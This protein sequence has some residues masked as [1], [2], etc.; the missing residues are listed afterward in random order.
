[1]V[2]K[3]PRMALLRMVLLKTAVLVALLT[4]PPAGAAQGVKVFISADMEGVVGAVTGDQL[5]P[6]G[7][8]YQKFREYMTQEVNA[9][10][11]GARAAGATEI[12][13][14]DSHGNGQNLLMDLLPD[15]I[16]LV[17][18][19]PREL[20]MMH[21]VDESFDAAILLG[22]HAST[23]NS[24]GV[25]AHTFSSANYHSVRLNGRVMTEGSVSAAIA[26]HFGVPVVM[27]SGDDAAVA[28]VQG[29]VGAVEGAVV[30]WNHGFHSATTVMPER[31]YALIEEAARRGV[32]RR[33]EIAPYTPSQ[34]LTLDLRFK[35][36]L[37]AEVLSYLPS[38]ERTDSHTIRYVG[39]DMV[40]ISRFLQFV[41]RYTASLSP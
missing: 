33:T 26:G 8:E 9:A 31:A 10:I 7:F 11:R 22:Y 29:E 18:S 39:A 13:V 20:G 16:L 17:R 4:F 5:G 25:R 23:D 40:E 35:N 38:V 30:K 32:E 24:E 1:M 28:E 37:P 14:A 15:D 12:V 19:W 36:Y 41:G 6:G 2:C 21:G 34:P 3:L 27:V